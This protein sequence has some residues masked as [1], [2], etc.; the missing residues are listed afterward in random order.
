MKVGEGRQLIMAVCVEQQMNASNRDGYER[1]H[2]FG[3]TR[4]RL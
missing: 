1:N 2:V 3:A 4:M